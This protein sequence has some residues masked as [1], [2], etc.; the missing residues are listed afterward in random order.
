MEWKIVEKKQI[1]SYLF[2]LIKHIS[3][4]FHHF[5]VI[6]KA[7]L[8]GGIKFQS[9]ESDRQMFA[10]VSRD[11]FQLFLPKLFEIDYLFM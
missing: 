2:I 4:D 9:W 7:V 11:P 8:F 3:I 5:L 10:N 1:F 6:S